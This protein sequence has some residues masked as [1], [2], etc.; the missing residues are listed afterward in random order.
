MFFTEKIPMHVMI[1]RKKWKCS[2]D[3]T[4]DLFCIVIS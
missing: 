2:K 4:S 3:T 1:I